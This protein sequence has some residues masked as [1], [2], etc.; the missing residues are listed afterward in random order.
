M[1]LQNPEDRPDPDTIVAHP[2][3]SVGWLPQPEEITPKLRESAPGP[4]QFSVGARVGRSNLYTK[5]FKKLCIQS[6]VGPFST[7]QKA[8]SSTY[9]EVAAEE[10][11][12]LTPAVPLP[13]DVVYRPFD[14][15]LQEQVQKKRDESGSNSAI[16]SQSEPEQAHLSQ[17]DGGT[18]SNAS[19]VGQKSFAAQQ[20]AQ[21]QPRAVPSMSR[22]ERLG[23]DANGDRE[24]HKS[25]SSMDRLGAFSLS[26]RQ[27][28]PNSKTQEHQAPE[29]SAVEARIG[30]D[31]VQQ[32]NQASEERNARH[33]VQQTISEQPLSLFS[34]RESPE[35]LPKS[36]PEQILQSLRN[37]HAELERALNSRSIASTKKSPASN[38]TIVVK[39]VDYTNKFGLGYILSN[40]SV[41]CIFRS[42]LASSGSTTGRIPPTCVIVRNAERH[43]QSRG[44][45]AYAD[46][47]QLVPVSGPKIEFYENKG[48]E[49]ISRVMVTPRKFMVTLGKEGQPG[50]LSRGKDEYDDRK[51]EKIVLWNKFAKYM[52]AFGRDQDYPY[53]EDVRRVDGESENGTVVTF[54]QRFGDVGCWGFS[55]G[56]FQV[57][58]EFPPLPY[59]SN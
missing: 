9:R 17:L 14:D 40:G 52:T 7:S 43:L 45:D 22:T 2:F 37:F 57:S 54:Y 46:R 15:W 41:G 49:G 12:G 19:R 18:L 16:K 10:K 1:I 11:A 23:R 21:H 53:D 55:D 59:I 31:L 32:L 26:T 25:Q 42:S 35:Y 48:E 33:E 27:S 50:R 51:I 58:I 6:N 56:S 36:K 5:N 20:R 38:P 39:W 3:F 8:P 29:A 28:K 30:T 13:D 34:A 4:N 44:N 47:H 24:S